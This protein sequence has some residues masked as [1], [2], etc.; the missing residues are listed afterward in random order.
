[1]T[2]FRVHA[3]LAVVAA[4]L[5]CLLAPPWPAHGLPGDAPVTAVSPHS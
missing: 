1:M 3:L 4:L 5:F 2:G